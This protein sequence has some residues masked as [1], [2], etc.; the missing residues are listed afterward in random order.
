MIKKIKNNKT[1]ETLII[2]RSL[3]KNLCN[4]MDKEQVGEFYGGF[5]DFLMEQKASEVIKYATAM[6]QFVLDSD[7]LFK[8]NSCTDTDGNVD[9]E[10]CLSSYLEKDEE[11]Y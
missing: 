1:G 11:Q 3:Y 2:D 6:V 5:Y 4:V 8:I 9:W 7:F 10:S